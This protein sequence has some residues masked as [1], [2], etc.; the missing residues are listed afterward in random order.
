MT[1]TIQE[2][3]DGFKNT[4]DKDYRRLVCLRDARSS[5]CFEKKD[6]YHPDLP[7]PQAFEFNNIQIA[8]LNA[9]DRMAAI[10]TFGSD[11]G[12]AA[13]P[14]QKLRDH[15]LKIQHVSD[16]LRRGE[17]LWKPEA[18]ETWMIEAIELLDKIEG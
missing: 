6:L 3:I 1:L 11:A 15:L 18:V 4:K 17:K 8:A 9:I 2:I 12:C 16:G 14:H 13:S 5:I 10:I 7:Q